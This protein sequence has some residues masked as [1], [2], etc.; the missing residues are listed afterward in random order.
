MVF[1]SARSSST[2]STRTERSGS[3][4]VGEAAFTGATGLILRQAFVD[5]DAQGAAQ[6]K[7]PLARAAPG[8]A[9]V[10]RPSDQEEHAR[11]RPGRR[12]DP[13]ATEPGL[14]VGAA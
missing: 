6:R 4:M 11:M 13:E 7:R 8:G 10:V 12:V 2:S 5:P 3:L 1:A 14:A 9:R